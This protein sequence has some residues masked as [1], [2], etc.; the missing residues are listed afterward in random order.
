MQN[1]RIVTKKLINMACDNYYFD[2]PTVRNRTTYKI[3]YQ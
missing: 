3:M 2:R 1:G